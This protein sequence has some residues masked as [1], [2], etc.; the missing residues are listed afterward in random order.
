MI[1]EWAGRSG[2]RL[3]CWRMKSE[4][5]YPSS[6]DSCARLAGA[7]FFFLFSLSPH[8]VQPP[9]AIRMVACEKVY[10][11]ITAKTERPIT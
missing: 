8:L 7:F 10:D 6:T 1:R 11:R 5:V 3:P 9:L 4:H 2:W